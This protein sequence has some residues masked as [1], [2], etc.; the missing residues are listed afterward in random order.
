MPVEKTSWIEERAEF[1][2]AMKLVVDRWDSADNDDYPPEHR[3]C[4]FDGDGC[5]NVSELRAI[6]TLNGIETQP[7]AQG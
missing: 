6:L 2:A 5:E 4:D 7:G 3:F 1:L